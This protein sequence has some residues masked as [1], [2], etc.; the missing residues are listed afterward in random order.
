M[1]FLTKKVIDAMLKIPREKFIEK[2]FYDNAYG[3]YPLSI[4]EKQT[5]SQPYIIALIRLCRNELKS[6]IFIEDSN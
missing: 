4:L 5:I 3:N 6:C 1:G 2:K